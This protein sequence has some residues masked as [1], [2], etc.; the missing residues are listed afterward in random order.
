[1]MDE[2]IMLNGSVE[3]LFD[4]LGFRFI[5]EEFEDTVPFEEGADADWLE[6]LEGA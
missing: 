2:M 5:P 6:M 3:E 4:E 1:M